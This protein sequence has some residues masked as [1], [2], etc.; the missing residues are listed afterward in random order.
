ML[1]VVYTTAT[2]TITTTTT[3]NTVT[4]ATTNFLRCVL[5]FSP[6]VFAITEDAVTVG[7]TLRLVCPV[8]TW[9]VLRSVRW[10]KGDVTLDPNSDRCVKHLH[11][12]HLLYFPFWFCLIEQLAQYSF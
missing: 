7:G 6:I 4:T 8:D 3:T 9:D 1:Y 10:Y 5:G 2:T 12:I 11:C